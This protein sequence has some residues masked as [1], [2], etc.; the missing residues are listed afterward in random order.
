MNSVAEAT[1][2]I[3]ETAAVNSVAEAIGSIE[4]TFSAT[5]Y[6]QLL[7]GMTVADF[8]AHFDEHGAIADRIAAIPS[9]EQLVAHLRDP[10]RVYTMVHM[11]KTVFSVGSDAPV[12]AADTGYG[13]NRY[14]A[15]VFLA[16]FMIRYHP[17]QVFESIGI[18]ESPLFEASVKMLDEWE[19]VLQSVR[20]NTLTREE[21]QE[22]RVVHDDF[23]VKFQAWKNPDEQRL[24]SRIRHA[25]LHLYSA[26][27][28]C[29]PTSRSRL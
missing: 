17:D 22:F 9:F 24:L 10:K 20:N 14:N 18:L 4:V 6:L 15:R 8:V 13:N 7:A 23:M 3:P 25:L 21:V 27:S 16:A 1:A 5:D 12:P 19:K 2:A 29:L 28:I 26:R 11:L